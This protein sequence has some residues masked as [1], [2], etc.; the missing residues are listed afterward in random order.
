MNH[1]SW[2][3]LCDAIHLYRAIMILEP[4]TMNFLTADKFNRLRFVADQRKEI[5]L[6]LSE[7]QGG[8]TGR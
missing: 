5:A 8:Q 1:E 2:K 4:S 7:F 3:I 6:Y